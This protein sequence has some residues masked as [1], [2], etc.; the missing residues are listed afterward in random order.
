MRKK[1][2]KEATHG[3]YMFHKDTLIAKYDVATDNWEDLYNQLSLRVVKSA[4]TMGF[5]L[6]Q[7]IQVSEDYLNDIEKQ[8]RH[9]EKIK[10]IDFWQVL[11]VFFFLYKVNKIDS[12]D[13]IFL[14]N[15]PNKNK[16]IIL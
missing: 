9:C 12:S 2:S 16:K 13:F 6:Q 10:V 15:K 5:N 14:K 1:R 7:Q 3:L 11:A 4:L 8:T